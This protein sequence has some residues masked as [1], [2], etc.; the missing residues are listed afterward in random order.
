[1]NTSSDISVIDDTLASMCCGTNTMLLTHGE[2]SDVI[3][4]I[5]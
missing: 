3:L 4:V 5:C 2:A 1:M